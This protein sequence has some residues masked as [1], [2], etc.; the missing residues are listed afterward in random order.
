MQNV[1][2]QLNG[3]NYTQSLT[4][5]TPYSIVL[6]TGSVSVGASVGVSVSGN[7]VTAGVFSFASHCQ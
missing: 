3:K 2:G 7:R 4:Q 5:Y 1:T 6:Y